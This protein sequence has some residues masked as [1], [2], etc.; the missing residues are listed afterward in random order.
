MKQKR[1]LGLVGCVVAAAVCSGQTQLYWIDVHGE[2]AIYRSDLDGSNPTELITG[3]FS[4]GFTYQSGSFYYGTNAAHTVVRADSS[5]STIATFNFTGPNQRVS[6][7]ASNSSYLFHAYEEDATIY[8]SS[9]SGTGQTLV[10]DQEVIEG[11]GAVN[12]QLTTLTATSSDLYWVAYNDGDQYLYSAGTDGSNPLLLH[13]FGA[14]SDVWALTEYNSQLYWSDRGL[15]GIYRSDLDGTNI[16]QLLDMDAVFGTADYV[17]TGIAVSEDGI[18]FSDLLD[19]TIYH[20]DLDGSNGELLLDM[21]AT[22]SD[23]SYYPVSLTLASA[24]PEP[25]TYALLGGLAVLGVTL[26]V[27]RRRRIDPNQAWSRSPAEV[28]HV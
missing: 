9:L 24:V 14:S 20:A 2:N 19:D 13:T 17:V 1:M 8:R 25:S 5:L 3:S 18:F 21:A 22:F 16:T 10:I 27:R 15:D 23:S 6:Y 26:W 4:R 28:A 12:T 7:L 11:E